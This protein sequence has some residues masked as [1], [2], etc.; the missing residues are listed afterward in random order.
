MCYS[1]F[2]SFPT[3]LFLFQDLIS[4]ITLQLVVVSALSLPSIKTSSLFPYLSWSWYFWKSVILL[5]VSSF[6]FFWFLLIRMGHFGICLYFKTS[7][8]SS[9]LRKKTNLY[10]VWCHLTLNVCSWF[11]LSHS[12]LATVAIIFWILQ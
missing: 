4:S 10:Q 7:K 11:T 3:V 12:D 9:T 8:V 5:N 6:S 1:N 2:S